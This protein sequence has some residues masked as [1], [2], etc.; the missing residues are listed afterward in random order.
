[1]NYYNK[2]EEAAKKILKAFENPND[3]PK[4]LAQVFINRQDDSPCRKWSWRNQFLVAINGYSEARGI[5]QWESVG[6][7][8][9]KGQKAFR[10]LSPSIKN[11]EDKDT[12]EKRKVMI[13]VRGTPV[14]GYEQTEG[15]ELPDRDSGK[16]SIENLPLLEV[17]EEWGLDVQVYKGGEMLGAYA[18]GK[19]IALGV[20]NLSVWLHELCHAAD[21][22]VTGLEGG[23]LDRESVTSATSSSP[24]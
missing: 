7:K 13:G 22:K 9:I 12:G 10:I 3:L 5:R 8:I 11:I 4:P 2:A 18:H 21:D 1:M 20:E 6:R 19:G 24:D 15:D 14:F 17:A 16:S 23:K